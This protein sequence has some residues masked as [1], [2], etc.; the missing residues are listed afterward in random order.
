[1]TRGHPAASANQ[2][3]MVASVEA[4]TWRTALM[5]AFAFLGAASQG[6]TA[7]SRASQRLLLVRQTNPAGPL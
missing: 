6:I 4:L 7:Y 2:M 3:V 5:L 1:M